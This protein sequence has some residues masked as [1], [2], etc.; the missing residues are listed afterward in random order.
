VGDDVLAAGER[1][2]QREGNIVLFSSTRTKWK[3]IE[4]LV[5]AWRA[6]ALAEWE[7]HITGPRRAGRFDGLGK[8][9]RQVSGRG[10]R[11][12]GWLR[13]S[14]ATLPSGRCRQLVS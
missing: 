12:S 5:T 14:G 11:R 10:R 2:W 7:L 4:K 9:L 8:D 3:R 13:A 1:Q 6:M